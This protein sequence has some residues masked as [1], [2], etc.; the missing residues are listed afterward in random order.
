MKR[1]LAA[2]MLLLSL[3]VSAGTWAD[4]LPQL[5]EAERQ[6]NVE[7]FDVVWQTINDRHFDTTFGGVDWAAVREELR[8]QIETAETISEARKVLRDMI[9]RLGL[10]HFGIIA[11]EVYRNIDRPKKKG[12]YG[13]VS[14]LRVRVLDGH[15]V[16]ADVLP[17]TPGEAAGIRPGWEIVDIDG[18]N[19]PELFPPIQEE[20]RNSL[21]L[22][23][24]LTAAV[25]SRLHGIVGD[26]V[27]V[28]FQDTDDNEVVRQIV[29]VES[30]GKKAL[31]GNLPPFYLRTNTDTLDGGIG[32]FA[33]NCF[34]DPITLMPAYAAA[35]SAFMDSP[36]II[37]DL[38]GNPGGIGVLATG[39][40]GWL[41]SEKNLYI[42]TLSTRD[43]ELKMIVNP[44]PKPYTGP[45]AVL[46]DGL[47]GSAAEFLAGGLKDIDRARIL[48][49]T[50]VG[51]ALPSTFEILP[52][53]DRF[54]YVF[55][56]Y[57]LGS[58][59]A[60]EGKGVVPHEEVKLTRKALLEGRDP[61]IEAAVAWIQSQQAN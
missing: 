4:E 9:G 39:M 18:E 8:P 12:D 26:T 10:S 20:F 58:G 3:L 30:T 2:A 24:Y 42:G 1:S 50:S 28:T 57:V 53:G 41:V 7:S 14:G 16:V 11:K 56:D 23:T 48:G 43:T 49:T 59:V 54:Q 38:R 32:Y 29:L 6:L 35:I 25:L 21:R 15:A 40:C 27:T 36:G 13:G 17:E 61:V 60:L 5:T 31:F 33:F 34:F 44:R 22:T 37:I 51:A 52:N 47:T 55:A 19:V 45:I 46:I